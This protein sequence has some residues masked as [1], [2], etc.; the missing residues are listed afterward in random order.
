MRSASAS[1][2]RPSCSSSGTMCCPPARSPTMANGCASTPPT[3]ANG[4]SRLRPTPPAPRPG[5]APRWRGSPR[6]GC[7]TPSG[8]PTARVSFRTSSRGPSSGRRHATA[9]RRTRWSPNASSE[10]RTSARVPKR[11]LVIAAH[12]DDELLG[13]G[14]TVALHVKAGDTVTTVIACEGESLRYGPAGVGQ[15]QHMRRAADV[16]GVADLRPLG[17]PDQR[18]DTLTRSEEH[19][20]ELQSPCN[21][22]CRL[23]LE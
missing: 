1:R 20:S 5:C 19:T 7:E 4:V 3:G 23:L 6:L 12:P 16:L 17:F 22:V 10:R 13:C 21:L 2:P 8:W 14:G 15:A 11:V 9:P 18:L